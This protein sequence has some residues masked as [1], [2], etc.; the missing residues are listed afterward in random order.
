[1]G[2]LSTSSTKVA[3]PIST[4]IKEPVTV[5]PVVPFDDTVYNSV[6]MSSATFFTNTNA[7]CPIQT[8]ELKAVGC[9]E[10]YTGKKLKFDKDKPDFELLALDSEI[11][12]WKETVCIV[13]KNSL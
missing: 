4:K 12:G 5:A 9:K 2:G 8:C 13:C 3:G 1:M 10:P 6:G 7:L 11:L